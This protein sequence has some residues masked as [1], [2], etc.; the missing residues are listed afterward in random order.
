MLA[1]TFVSE[2]IANRI[3]NWQQLH[4]VLD[5]RPSPES[6]TVA[7]KPRLGHTQDRHRATG[8]GGRSEKI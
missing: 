3:T 1:V 7:K 6:K 5:S 2:S 4:R 8:Q